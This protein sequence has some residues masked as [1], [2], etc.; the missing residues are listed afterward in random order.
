MSK[1]SNINIGLPPLSKV[2]DKDNNIF[3]PHFSNWITQVGTQINGP[4]FYGNPSLL[5]NSD[6]NFANGPAIIVNVPDG[7]EFSKKWFVVGGSNAATFT[8]SR[9]SYDVSG[10][11][12]PE[13]TGSLYYTTLQINTLPS[14]ENF[15]LYQ[16]FTGNQFVR[17]Y[18]N[19]DVT[20]SLK[21][22]NPNSL[23]LDAKFFISI[24][25]GSTSHTFFGK[26]FDLVTGN[27]ESASLITTD[28][29]NTTVTSG[30]VAMGIIILS[31]C[32]LPININYIKV[33]F[34]NEPTSLY[35]D[36][37]LEAARIANS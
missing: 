23:S 36:H 19:R 34:D 5:Y 21:I 25:D 31:T 12:I 13:E 1:F 10:A 20:F 37:A 24:N 7:T 14:S 35:I 33:E 18:Q 16:V 2:I 11:G 30:Y 26:K 6:F 3:T 32:V 9:V 8:L 22:F 15:L 17:L 29:L 28:I 27:N 4:N